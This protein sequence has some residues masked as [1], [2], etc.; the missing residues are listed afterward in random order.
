MG[1]L[2]PKKYIMAF[3]DSLTK[4]YYHLGM[5]YHPYT[6]KLNELLQKN[7][8]N[9]KVIDFGLNGE[10]SL[11]MTERISTIFQLYENKFDLVII[12]SGT[13]DL[14][15]GIDINEIFE[16]IKLINKKVSQKNLWSIITTLPENQ[17]DELEVSYYEKKKKLNSLIRSLSSDENK[18]IIC[19]LEKEMP[20]ISL[21]EEN[22]KKYLDDALHFTPEGYNQLGKIFYDCLVFHS[23]ILK[24]EK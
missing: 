19:D 20:F 7:K 5:K 12:F 9:Y 13:N 15:S 16:N 11:S 8:Y 18:T 23:K 6:I 3:G 1:T 22:K 21:N 10:K 2:A 17:I 14:G 4:G 24:L